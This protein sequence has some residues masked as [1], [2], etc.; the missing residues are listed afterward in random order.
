M[1][2]VDWERCPVLW[3]K[4]KGIWLK[5]PADGRKAPR[6]CFVETVHFHTTPASWNKCACHLRNESRSLDSYGAVWTHPW[7][8]HIVEES[9]MCDKLTSP[10]FQSER[11]T[12]TMVSSDCVEVK[13]IWNM[14]GF[15]SRKMTYRRQCACFP[16]LSGCTK[17][18]HA[19]IS[20]ISNI[21]SVTWTSKYLVAK[22]AGLEMRDHDVWP[23]GPRA[24]Q[25]VQDT[26]GTQAFQMASHLEAKFCWWSTGL[27]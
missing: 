13:W 3:R 12:L 22:P 7:V 21:N 6:F 16:H 14:D 15:P 19:N 23:K 26:L 1:Q 27:M 11:L 2:L 4:N 24:S 20:N 25:W 8:N 17:R 5:T 18:S 9:E 10:I